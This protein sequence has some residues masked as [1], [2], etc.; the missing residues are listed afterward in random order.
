[1]SHKKVLPV[2]SKTDV[3]KLAGAIAKSIRDMEDVTLSCLGAG[4]MLTAGKSLAALK[5]F[6]SRE[7]IGVWERPFFE[8]VLINGEERNSVSI[9]LEPYPLY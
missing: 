9:S 5:S 1:M 7:K 3:N 6:L 2:S 8:V 4:A